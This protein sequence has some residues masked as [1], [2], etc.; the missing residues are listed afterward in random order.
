MHSHE[1]LPLPMDNPDIFR[2]SEEDYDYEDDST[3]CR[4]LL[5]EKEMRKSTSCCIQ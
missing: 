3:D 4:D 2:D 5:D 1:Y